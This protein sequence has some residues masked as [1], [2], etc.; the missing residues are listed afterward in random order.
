MNNNMLIKLILYTIA[1]YG[2]V[3]SG[4]KTGQRIPVWSDGVNPFF[5]TFERQPFV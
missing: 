5:N 2:I 4:H 3:C 1:V